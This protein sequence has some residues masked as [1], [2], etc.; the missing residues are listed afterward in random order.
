M[1]FQPKTW[2]RFSLGVTA[3]C[4]LF[5]LAG[6]SPSKNMLAAIFGGDAGTPG[7]GHTATVDPQLTNPETGYH[8]ARHFQKRGRHHL[9][10]EELLKV[11]RADPAH[12][13]AYNA[14]G[15]SYDRLREFDLAAAAYR[16]ALRI[17]PNLD[18]VYNNIGYSNLLQGN[19]DA[20]ADAFK[21]AVALNTEKALYQNN[22]ALAHARLGN[23]PPDRPAPVMPS[24][25]AAVPET[26]PAAKPPAAK[27]QVLQSPAPKIAPTQI[28]A[29]QTAETREPIIID[30]LSDTDAADTLVPAEDHVYYTIQLGV[31][32][33]LDKAMAALKHARENGLDAPYI[34]KVHRRGP[35]QPYYRVRAGKYQDRDQAV[36]RAAGIRT[37]TPMP[38]Y[39]TQVAG[40]PEDLETVAEHQVAQIADL[41]AKPVIIQSNADI[42]ILNGNGVRHMARECRQYLTKQGISVNRIANAAHF[43]HPRTVIYYSPGYYGQARQIL[44]RFQAIN[45]DGRLIKSGTLNTGIRI[46]LGRDMVPAADQLG[47]LMKKKPLKA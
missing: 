40:T 36:R 23:P 43:F 42:E 47:Q 46:V 16:E 31:F 39:I 19:L 6:C 20:A 8:L 25:V 33:A 21:T 26:T 7:P 32:Y 44:E 35:Y 4:G 3:F 30:D 13:D 28:P 27:A 9:A 1:T 22:L 24:T 2:K 18:Y 14:L 12:A 29:L 37:K 41:P 45:A 5:L 38:A 15:V 11:V 17:D 34:T 10:V